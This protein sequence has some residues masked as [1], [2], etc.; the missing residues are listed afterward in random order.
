MNLACI[1][2][3]SADVVT[4]TE[5]IYYA[6]FVL[7]VAKRHSSIAS[8]ANI[9]QNIKITSNV[10]CAA[11]IKLPTSVLYESAATLKTVLL[12]FESSPL[13]SVMTYDFVTHYYGIYCTYFNANCVIIKGLFVF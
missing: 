4:D 6:T 8:T 1:I 7:S 11:D 12:N 5:K 2:V 13:Y 3:T 9:K 10:I